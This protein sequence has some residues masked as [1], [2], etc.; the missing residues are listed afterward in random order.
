MN[1]NRGGQGSS[2]SI[3]H[4]GSRRGTSEAGGSRGQ[5]KS[6][7]A[8]RP[9]VSLNRDALR[10]SLAQKKQVGGSSTAAAVDRGQAAATADKGQAAATASRGQAAA[11]DPKG[12]ASAEKSSS[13]KGKEKRR[14]EDASRPPRP[15]KVRVTEGPEGGVGASSSVSAPVGEIPLGGIYVP[16]WRIREG[17]SVLTPEV[18]SEMFE[19]S[20]LLR[21]LQQLSAQGLHVVAQEFAS[22]WARVSQICPYEV[23]NT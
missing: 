23:Y 3:G 8:S 12:K 5:G 20:C 11:T 22:A 9:A 1:T 2:G 13:D 16:A 15:N 17:S 4:G 18:A 6:S 21:D 19:H 14:L 7:S 10:K